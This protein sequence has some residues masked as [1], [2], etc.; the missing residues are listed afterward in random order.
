MTR[1]LLAGLGLLGL[2]TIHGLDHLLLQDRALPG[3]IAVLGVIESSAVIAV[4]VLAWRGS[5][6]APVAA[7]LAGTGVALA[8]VT[9]HLL[10]E[11]GALSDPYADASL[12]ASSW[13][14][15]FAGLAGGLTLAL[16]GALALSE[17]ATTLRRS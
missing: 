10:P 14:I 11:W 2:Q 7:L 5:R 17:R 12:D 4:M 8:F 15:M 1:I 9:A 16:A 3:A 6:H 13:V